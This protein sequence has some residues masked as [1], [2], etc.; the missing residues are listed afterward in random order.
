MLIESD[1][2]IATI[3]E[4]D[5]LRDDAAY[6]I[7][8]IHKGEIT[9]AYASSAALQEVIFWL[10]KENRAAEVVTAV[11]SLLDI[12]NLEW[13]NVSK[14][15]C[16]NAAALIEEYQMGPFDAYHAA[17]A[18]SMDGRIISSDHIFDKIKN[19]ERIDQKSI[20]LK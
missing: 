19:I 4:N 9:G 20:R 1:T 6:I 10:L 13:I 17:T 15:I 12:R 8:A 16:L 2:F 5:R 14:E 18:L 11:S 7:S 3:K